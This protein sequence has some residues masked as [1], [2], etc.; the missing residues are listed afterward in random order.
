MPCLCCTQI[1]NFTLA[2]LFTS[3]A[4]CKTQSLVP[5]SYPLTRKALKGFTAL[6]SLLIAS[7]AIFLVCLANSPELRAKSFVK[8][9]TM[10][11]KPSPLDIPRCLTVGAAEGAVLELGPGPGKFSFFFFFFF[12]SFRVL[13]A[14]TQAS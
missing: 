10:L 8:L 14:Y 13:L 4:L 12:F 7:F 9:C 6:V 5:K 3:L 2:L 11:A 1:P